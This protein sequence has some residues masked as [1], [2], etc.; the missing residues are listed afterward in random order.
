MRIDDR[1]VLEMLGRAAKD[2][3]IVPVVREFEWRHPDAILYA[4]K[5]MIPAIPFAVAQLSSNRKS[6]RAW[7][8]LARGAALLFVLLAMRAEELAEKGGA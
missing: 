5:E 6:L 3:A 4:A 7:A 1:K 2:P 8:Q